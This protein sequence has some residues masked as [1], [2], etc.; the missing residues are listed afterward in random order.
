MARSK[1]PKIECIGTSYTTIMV[2]RNSQ[3]EHPSWVSAGLVVVPVL[4]VSSIGRGGRDLIAL[5]VEHVRY[6]DPVPF[7]K[8]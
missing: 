5:N 6:V 3:G 2:R 1:K 4:P 7:V 8:R